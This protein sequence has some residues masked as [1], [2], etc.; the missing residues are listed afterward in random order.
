MPKPPELVGGVAAMP[1]PAEP[2]AGV[3]AML[4]SPNAGA[5][6]LALDALANVE[7]DP[8]GLAPGIERFRA[9]ASTA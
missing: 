6:L 3:A 7:L 8:N 4:P 9:P 2:V 1:N 5:L